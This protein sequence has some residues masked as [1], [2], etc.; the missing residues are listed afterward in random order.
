MS[1]EF[2]FFSRVA[3]S[4]SAA[5][6]QFGV[7]LTDGAS[8]TLLMSDG[9]ASELGLSPK[10][11]LLA[12]AFV[13]CDPFEELLLGPTYGASKV[14]RMAGE[15][16]T[17]TV[18]L[19]TDTQVKDEGFL[20]DINNILSSGEIPNLF[21]RDEL[22]EIFDGL[23]KPAE[24]A[25]IEETPD[26]MW[27]FFIERVRNKLHIVLA[28]SPVG[29]S[30]RQRCMFYPALVNCTNIDWFHTWQIGRAHV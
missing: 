9:K 4:K 30:L 13:A 11:E 29:E 8:A 10:A 17:Q 25:G 3:A 19:F 7:F 22:P 27:K 28:M 12:Y 23:R 18:F 2:S 6:P 14:L 20:E 5:L 21:A 1:P 26:Q 24:K 16:N 15:S